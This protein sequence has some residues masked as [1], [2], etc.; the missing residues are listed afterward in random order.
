M[1][2]NKENLNEKYA[3]MLEIAAVRIRCLK[4]D[5]AKGTIDNIEKLSNDI[6]EQGKDEIELEK[7]QE[8]GKQPNSSNKLARRIFM[9]EHVEDFKL[10]SEGIPEEE[11][12][13]LIE[14]MKNQEDGKS[15][16]IDKKTANDF[17]NYLNAFTQNIED[18]EKTNNIGRTR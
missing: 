13:K 15:Y 16:T 3:E 2:E 7:L 6:I 11:M 4:Y 5:I 14:S 18:I 17:E 12:D 8:E 10:Q 9:E 1:K